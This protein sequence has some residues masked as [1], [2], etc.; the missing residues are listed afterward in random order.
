M[1]TIAKVVIALLPILLVLG[2]IRF[3]MLGFQGDFI[4]SFDSWLDWFANL[5]RQILQ[6]FVDVHEFVTSGNPLSFVGIFGYVGAVFA[7]PV[8]LI[9]WLFSWFSIA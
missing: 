4:P 7:A 2:L 8:N 5:P 3:S 6:P 1:K 9:I